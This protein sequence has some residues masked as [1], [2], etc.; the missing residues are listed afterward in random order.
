MLAAK[1]ADLNW[2]PRTHMIERET[3]P[4]QISSHTLAM[5]RVFPP[6]PRERWEEGEEGE[7]DEG[8]SEKGNIKV[9]KISKVSQS[10]DIGK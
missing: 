7:E 4:H 2:I 1:P 5:V 3:G 9:F 8:G 6:Q 10:F